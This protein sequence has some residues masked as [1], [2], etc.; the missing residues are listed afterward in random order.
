MG[1]LNTGWKWHGLVLAMYSDN[2]RQQQFQ[3]VMRRCGNNLA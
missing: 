1:Q 3:G 2:D